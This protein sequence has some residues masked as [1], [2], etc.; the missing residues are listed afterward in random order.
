MKDAI[1]GRAKY[2]E[3]VTPVEKYRRPDDFFTMEK[4]V[5]PVSEV[6]QLFLAAE[7]MRQGTGQERANNAV[8]WIKDNA[9]SAYKT[10]LKLKQIE[11]DER[12]KLSAQ[13]NG[14]SGI[15]ANLGKRKQLLM[16]MAICTVWMSTLTF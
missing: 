5:G 15:L 12:A 13:I 1:S 4:R 16:L 11:V 2:E 10:I 6:E 14:D 8:K 9:P 3:K 7:R